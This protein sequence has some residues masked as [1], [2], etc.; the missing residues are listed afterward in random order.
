MTRLAGFILLSFLAIS[1]PMLAQPV[2]PKPPGF[3]VTPLT[4]TNFVTVTNMVSATNSLNLNPADAV[5]TIVDVIPAKYQ[6]AALALI[7][8][9]MLG[10]RTYASLKAGGKLTGLWSGL[11]LGHSQQQANDIAAVKVKV[12]LPAAPLPSPVPTK[13]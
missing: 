5:N 6:K 1:L 8:L 3:P 2:P 4:V 9:L 11:V 13:I 7:A 10:G 12:G